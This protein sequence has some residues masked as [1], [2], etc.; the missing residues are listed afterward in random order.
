MQSVGVCLRC[1]CLVLAFSGTS[2]VS[3]G[4]YDWTGGLLNDNANPA[5]CDVIKDANG[6]IVV[7]GTEGTWSGDH[8]KYQV[9]DGNWDADRNFFDPPE[10]AGRNG[11]CWA[12]IGFTSP[13]IVTK[14]RV[15][16]RN[17]WTVRMEGCLIQGANEADF[18]D[19]ETIHEFAA[20]TANP[21]DQWV[22]N[23]DSGTFKAY[24]Y[25][26]IIGPV[27]YNGAKQPG[28]MCGN[29][30][31]LE[32]YGFD[33]AHLP[34][35]GDAPAAP[36]PVV[37]YAEKINGKVNMYLWESDAVFYEFQRR[38]DGSDYSRFLVHTGLNN[39]WQTVLVEDIA[40]VPAYYRLRAVNPN[41]ASDWTEWRFDYSAPVAG[42]YIGITSCWGNQGNYGTK[43]FDGDCETFGDAGAEDASTNN[44]WFGRDFGEVKQVT[45]IRYMRRPGLSS[46]GSGTMV[47]AYFQTADDPDFTENVTNIYTVASQPDER[48]MTTVELEVPVSTRYIRYH[49]ADGQ[50]GAVAEIEF[51]DYVTDAPANFTI[52]AASAANTLSWDEYSGSNDEIDGVRVYRREHGLGLAWDVLATLPR[53]ATTYVDTSVRPGRHY[54]YVVAYAA[55]DVCEKR[56]GVLVSGVVRLERDSSDLTQL[57]SGVSPIWSGYPYRTDNTRAMADKAFDSDVSTC[58]DLS[59]DTGWTNGYGVAV[60]VDLGRPYV[61]GTARACSRNDG[62]WSRLNGAVICGSND[63]DNH[64]ARY[65]VITECFSVSRKG[66]WSEVIGLTTKAYRYIFV[67]Q[68]GANTQFWG[69]VAELELFGFRPYVPGFVVLIR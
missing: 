61:L 28:E 24:K 47:G 17:N 32:L 53:S 27:A 68:P 55:G 11:G 54:D 3:F 42:K 1:V 6:H 37:K 13:K 45:A 48:T 49:A 64:F 8:T 50:H 20:L 7:Y 21:M 15:A 41:G 10:A 63:D 29:C 58:V 33:A 51:C 59:T 39:G 12:G 52:T 2:A 14:I 46:S 38:I 5:N 4:Y 60:G 36:S 34:D 18:S 40:S 62:N 69:N 31:E 25:F 57:K 26:R 66:E 22:T 35:A 56:S 19:A 65:D 23:P 30:T 16:A 44:V 67:R 9:F 43:V